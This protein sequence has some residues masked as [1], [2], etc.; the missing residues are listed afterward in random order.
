MTNDQGVRIMKGFMKQAVSVLCL[1]G[2]LG[3]L[4]GCDTYRNLVDP[5]YPDR[6]M[7]TSR[8]EVVAAL[9]PQ[10]NNGHALDQTVWNYHFEI[11]SDKLTEGGRQHLAYLARRR[12]APDNVVF[13]QTAQDINYDP[14]APAKF[15]E[16]RVQLDNRRTQ[17]IQNYLTAETAGRGVNF[18]V[19]VHDPGEVGISAVAG[20]LSAQKMNA[21]AVGALPGAAG[22]GASNVSGGGGASGGGGGGK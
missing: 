5:C 19:L 21:A 12:P 15:S 7:Q 14:A 20:G 8:Q 13:L 4:G 18:D 1:S 10:V 17:A 2:G 11:G 22:A 3:I 16:A 6:Y 9:A